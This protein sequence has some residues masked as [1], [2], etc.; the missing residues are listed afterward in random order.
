[1]KKPT[2][3]FV[4]IERLAEFLAPILNDDECAAVW[5]QPLKKWCKEALK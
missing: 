1:M 2:T 4:A 3:N 5:Q